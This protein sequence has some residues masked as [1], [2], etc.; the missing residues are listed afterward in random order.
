M[1]KSLVA[2]LFASTLLFLSCQSD[3][4]TA[5]LELT[6]T[7]KGLT[8]GTLYIQKIQDTALV[9]LDSIVIKGK[10]DFSS[11]LEVDGAEV[12]YLSLDRGHSKSID[13]QLLFFAEPGKIDIQTSLKSFY[14]D[15][16][17]TGSKNQDTYSDYLKTRSLITDKQNELLIEILQAQKENQT[18][19]KDSLLQL[20][21]RIAGR[22]YL[23]A[24]NFAI[25]HS[26]T[27][28][29]PYIALTEIYDR[30]IKY[31]DTIQNSLSKE[32]ALGRYGKQLKQFIAERK[33]EE[34]TAP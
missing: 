20:S 34:Q 8:Q 6:G 23:N 1:K 18:S 14:A 30:P 24:V 9:V 13:N 22:K 16:K 4:G 29:A 17:I 25:N 10:S 33:A 19:K 2:G 7:I 12:F 5:N 31:L 32:V 3:K 26:N 27:D 11:L 15:A 28:V 21:T